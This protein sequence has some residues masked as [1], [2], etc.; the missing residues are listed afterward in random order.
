MQVL[1]DPQGAGWVTPRP[2]PGPATAWAVRR[3]GGGGGGEVREGLGLAAE[4]GST[5]GFEPV[6]EEI[7]GI[8]ETWFVYLALQKILF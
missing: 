2:V 5:A 1:T 6:G 8:V 3:R 4:C 7:C